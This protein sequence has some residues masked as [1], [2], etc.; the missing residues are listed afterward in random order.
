MISLILSLAFADTIVYAPMTNRLETTIGHYFIDKDFHS[1]KKDMLVINF[2][3]CDEE[4]L[5]RECAM[6]KGYWYLDVVEFENDEQYQINI[7]LYDENSRIVSQSIIN[8]RYVI[9]KIPQK[10]II[11]GTKVQGGT[12]APTKTEIEKPPLIVTG[13]QFL[14]FRHKERC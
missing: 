6:V 12:I 13:K 5:P 4:Q 3:D 8:K 14:S 2:A 10:T 9:E 7:F 11:K 1:R